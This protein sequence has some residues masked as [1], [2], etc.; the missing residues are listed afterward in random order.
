M[1]RPAIRIASVFGT[2]AALTLTLA[3][4]SGGDSSTSGA[5]SS[6]GEKTTLSV[7]INSDPSSLLLWESLKEGYEAANKN[8][9]LNLDANPSGSEGDNLV[10]TKMS[11]G[12][13]DDLLYYNSG[14]QFQALDPVTNLTPLDDQPWVDRL[15]DNAA[16]AMSSGDSLYG[17]PVG[18]SFSGAM[19]YNVEIYEELGLSVPKTWDEFIANCEKIKEAGYT[20]VIQTYG[21]TYTSQITVLGD[22]YNVLA[23]DPSWAE[24]YTAGKSKY[25]EEPALDG[26]VKTGELEA[27]GFFNENYPSATYDEGVRMLVEGEGA[28]YPMLTNNVSSAIGELFPEAGDKVGVFPIPSRDSSI[29]GLTVWMPNAIY[30]PKTTEGT[31]LDAA[32]KFIEWLVTPEA[33]TIQ[34]ESVTLGGPFMID[35]CSLPEDSIRL[36]KDMQTYFDE[37]KTGLALEFLSPIK[38]PALEHILVEVGS[39][40]RSAKDG[41]ALYDEDVK[42]QALQLGLEGWE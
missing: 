32:K 30:I 42:K 8:V 4:C 21:D 7:F 16:M 28:H 1:K 38:G 33:C 14:S 31:Q 35:G 12:E 2:A 36:V 11:T 39:G 22:F 3:A 5:D 27:K 13:M 20:A 34:A 18:V 25:A 17:A 29:N 26:F 37:G 23:Q 19:N 6:D 24:D 15:D 41:A 9:T 10:R 40:T